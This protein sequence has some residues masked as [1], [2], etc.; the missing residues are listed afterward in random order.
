MKLRKI[1]GLYVTLLFTFLFSSC[2]NLFSFFAPNQ[3]DEITQ[4]VEDTENVRT[5]ISLGE[6]SLSML[7]YEAAFEAFS[8]AVSIA[9]TNTTA[10]EGMCTAYLFWNI[11]F[12]NV[13]FA[14]LDGSYTNFDL[15]LLYDVSE[16]LATN[17]HKIYESSA[18]GVIP[19]DDVNLNLNF[20][21]F[22]SLYGAFYLADTDEDRDV[23]TDTNDFFV[24][25]PDFTFT[26]QLPDTL[27]FVQALSLVSLVSEKLGNFTTL[28]NYS[29]DSLDTITNQLRASNTLEFV[30]T[31]RE[32]LVLVQETLISNLG[33]ISNL[34]AGV[35]FG[36]TNP[37]DIT[38][39]LESGGYTNVD[40]LTNALVEAGFTN[41][42]QL[43][44]EVEDA[45][46]DLTNFEELLTNFYGVTNLY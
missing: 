46:P 3:A 44:E 11:P 16:M 34:T 39:Y 35:Q 25:Y 2:F 42:E 29:F 45:F 15:N 38:N 1:L 4:R 26:N 40:V 28:L 10:I 6:R 24:V 20:F 30:E 13:L 12:T 23:T 36:I 43:L 7:E 37:Y 41:M 14:A 8:K 27:D 21:I 32:P 17:L 18:D 9:P 5:L 33:D 19:D 31:V 22:N